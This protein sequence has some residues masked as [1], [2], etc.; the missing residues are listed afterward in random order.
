MEIRK[1]TDSKSKR[2]IEFI[3]R[4]N[5]WSN[6]RRKRRGEKRVDNEDE[7]ESKKAKIEEGTARPIQ[8]ESNF[9]LKGLLL[10]E[11]K[12]SESISLQ[13]QWIEGGLMR[14]SMNQILQY[15]KNHL[16]DK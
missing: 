3:A 12:D 16:F 14:E 4:E 5:T 7:P 15:M 10:V 2:A 8:E 9:F 11:E 6:Q 1:V 13:M